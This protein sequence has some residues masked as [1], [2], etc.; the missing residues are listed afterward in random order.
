MILVKWLRARPH[1]LRELITMEVSKPKTRST[2][3]KPAEFSHL[4][5][6]EQRALELGNEAEHSSGR[7]REVLIQK[8]KKAANTSER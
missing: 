4:T 2:A 7:R 8:S 1:S 6:D 3:T 5:K